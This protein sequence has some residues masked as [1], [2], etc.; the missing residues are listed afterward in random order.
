MR[1]LADVLLLERPI[2]QVNIDVV[3][4][5]LGAQVEDLHHGCLENQLLSLADEE[6]ANGQEL[7]PGKLLVPVIDRT[8]YVG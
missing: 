1:L 6:L 3:E 2:L 8:G 7:L 4:D 5:L